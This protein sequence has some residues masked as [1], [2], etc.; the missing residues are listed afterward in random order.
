MYKPVPYWNIELFASAYCRGYASAQGVANVRLANYNAYSVGGGA[1]AQAANSI[2]G[3]SYRGNELMLP[4]V[5]HKANVSVLGSTSTFFNQ[6]GSC[7][8]NAS[9][10][11]NMSSELVAIGVN[12]SANNSPIPYF[13]EREVYVEGYPLDDL[14]TI[15]EGEI[16]YLR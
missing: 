4:G 15:P 7:S 14:D 5:K 6:G 3:D 9:I 11:F 12:G 10:N 1:F 13:F 8:S 16:W 2:S